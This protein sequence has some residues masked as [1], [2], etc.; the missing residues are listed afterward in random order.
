MLRLELG[1]FPKKSMRITLKMVGFTSD[2]NGGSLYLRFPD[3]KP[4][5]LEEEII[6]VVDGWELPGIA[7]EAQYGV[8]G[9]T[10]GRGAYDKTSTTQV[11]DLDLGF[12]D[13]QK[14]YFSVMLNSRFG[15]GVGGTA[16]NFN[17]ASIVFEVHDV[18]AAT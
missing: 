16:D 11:F 17:N 1:F 2:K 8:L 9:S 14:D 3:V 12:M 10:L 5:Y 13:V 18:T 6:D 4:S 15:T 7:L